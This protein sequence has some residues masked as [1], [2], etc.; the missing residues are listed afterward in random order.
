MTANLIKTLLAKML[1]SKFNKESHIQKIQDSLVK[2]YHLHMLLQPRNRYEGAPQ[3]GAAAVAGSYGFPPFNGGGAGAN[4]VNNGKLG[5]GGVHDVHAS[6]G[7][8]VGNL[9]DSLVSSMVRKFFFFFFTV[10]SFRR[11]INSCILLCSVE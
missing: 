3:E 4:A 6:C 9:G 2:E 7:T 10:L 11:L 1:S 5:T 8:A